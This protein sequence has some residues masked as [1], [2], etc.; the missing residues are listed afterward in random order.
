MGCCSSL[1]LG[2][3]LDTHGSGAFEVDDSQDG[4]GPEHKSHLVGTDRLF[5]AKESRYYYS[6]FVSK[7]NYKDF[8]AILPPFTSDQN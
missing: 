3:I 8:K 6:F 4:Y 2:G 5:C 1:F 7:F